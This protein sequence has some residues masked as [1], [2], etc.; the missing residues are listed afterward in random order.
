MIQNYQKMMKIEKAMDEYN[1]G[2]T[3]TIE[4]IGKKRKNACL[5]I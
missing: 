4:D 5:E 1:K 3:M 2:E